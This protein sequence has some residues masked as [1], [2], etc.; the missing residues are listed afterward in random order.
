MDKT[1]VSRCGIFN[2]DEMLKEGKLEMTSEH[3][4]I[5]TN[6]EFQEWLAA[7]LQQLISSEHIDLR[8]IGGS[9]LF[10]SLTAAAELHNSGNSMKLL[11]RLLGVTVGWMTSNREE[12]KT[13]QNRFQV[14][15]A[16]ILSEIYTPEEF[17]GLLDHL[18]KLLVPQ[19]QTIHYLSTF[20]KNPY[21]FIKQ[22]EQDYQKF[23]LR[24]LELMENPLLYKE[25][26]LCI[27]GLLYYRKF[28]RDSAKEPVAQKLLHSETEKE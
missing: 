23:I 20:Y 27:S 8:K 28:G 5:R 19:P 7:R 6:E 17:K 21:N 4:S 11:R 25:V 26:L 3:L 1:E 12:F 13:E 22:S 9:L 2:I 18:V 24:L 15:L 16:S 14:C 10:D